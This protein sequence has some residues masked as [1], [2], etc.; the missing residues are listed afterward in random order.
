MTKV[1]NSMFKWS[2][3]FNGFVRAVFASSRMFFLAPATESTLRGGHLFLLDFTGEPIRN[4]SCPECA[5]ARDF[6]RS[7][8][9]VVVRPAGRVRGMKHFVKVAEQEQGAHDKCALD[10]PRANDMPKPVG[11]SCKC[12]WFSII[13]RPSN[14]ATAPEVTNDGWIQNG[15]LAPKLTCFLLRWAAL[16][17]LTTGCAFDVSHVRQKP[18]SFSLYIGGFSPVVLAKDLKV[19]LGTGFPTVLRAGTRWVKV[20]R[21]ETGDVYTT[22]DQIVKAEGSNIYEAYIV[23]SAN[24]ITGF[25]LPVEKTLSALSKQLP[26]EFQANQ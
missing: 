9:H 25:Y 19:R 12:S 17:L 1:C 6:C 10:L 20:G 13:R 18:A 16:A 23:P 14:S 5:S 3:G 11:R 4:P 2:N 26:I 24:C 21:T 22:K 15:R 7:F 8:G